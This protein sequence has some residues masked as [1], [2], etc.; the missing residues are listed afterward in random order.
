M[1]EILPYLTH[2]YVLVFYGVILWQVEQISTGWITGKL[3]KNRFPF[4]LR[5][6]LWGG[7]FIIFDDELLSRYNALANV[8]YSSSPWWMYVIIG[9][10]VD[11]I[12]S[13]FFEKKPKEE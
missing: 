13:Y 5:S 4:I 12:R 1:K 7:I 3:V 10:T 2:E 9:F 11:F 8:D 6:M